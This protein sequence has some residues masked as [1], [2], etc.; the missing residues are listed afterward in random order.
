[1]EQALSALPN[2]PVSLGVVSRADQWG[3]SGETKMLLLWTHNFWDFHRSSRGEKLTAS[4]QEI[5]VG[6]RRTFS[7]LWRGR[8]TDAGISGRIQFVK[9]KNI[10]SEQNPVR[11]SPAFRLIFSSFPI[12]YLLSAYDLLGSADGP[13][14][15]G[16]DERS[17][18]QRPGRLDYI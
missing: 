18:H 2:G 13:A 7:F 6:E 1:M 8:K 15:D 16:G 4:I 17:I 3:F 14:W 5:A 9:T 10:S 11:S 12:R